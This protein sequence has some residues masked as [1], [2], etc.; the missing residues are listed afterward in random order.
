MQPQLPDT[1]DKDESLKRCAVIK[2][3]F[4]GRFVFVDDLAEN[5]LGMPGENLFG[6]SIEEFLDRDSYDI[7]HSVL[8][9]GNRCETRYKMTELVFLD[10]RHNEYCL[11]VV[12]S[13]N[14]IA[15]NPANYQMIISP[16]SDRA[17]I[18]VDNENCDRIFL[19]LF[20]HVSGLKDNADWKT[21]SK[22]LLR[23]ENI[24]QVGIY[25]FENNRLG[26]IASKSPRINLKSMIDLNSTNE[27][28]TNVVLK[29]K[30]GANSI[31]LS[32]D[33]AEED[34]NVLLTDACYPLICGK[35]CWGLLRMIHDGEH[36][37]MDKKLD[38]VAKFIG[39]ALAPF[40]SSQQKARMSMA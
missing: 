18:E 9:D 1:S 39:N 5:L 24:M 33:A 40:V 6:R 23:I 12:I 16:P 22:I 3:D 13:L 20:D 32:G 30:P 28:H 25:R 36:S 19:S 7:L 14:F 38:G 29:Q 10:E 4:N 26:L 17:E 31:C 2:I 8:N 35:N 27:D 11:S 34:E 21:L 15:G 37:L